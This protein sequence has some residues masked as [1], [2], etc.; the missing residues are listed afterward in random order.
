MSNPN[1]FGSADDGKATGDWPPAPPG[2]VKGN[3]GG[4][5]AWQKASVRLDACFAVPVGRRTRRL[6][7]S[8]LSWLAV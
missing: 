5:P 6:E 3:G 8:C 4:P 1:E 2:T 7:G